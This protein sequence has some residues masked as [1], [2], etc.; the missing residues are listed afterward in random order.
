[1]NFFARVW[2]NARDRRNVDRRWQIVH[3]GVEHGLH[4]LVLEGRPANHRKDF[5]LQGRAPQCGL[6]FGLTDG[7]AFDV[8]MH[9]LV[10]IVVFDNGLDQDLMVGSG[11]LLQL[12]RNFF[13]FVLGAQALVVP[14]DRLHGH[15]VDDA[16]EFIFLADGQL[17]RYRA[18]V[19][20][21]ADGIDGV[22][23]VGTHLVHLVDEANAGNTVLIGLTPD[24]FR[25]RLDA[26]HGIEHGTG[27]I[28]YAQRALYLGGE[29]HVAGGIDNVDANIFPDAGGRG[30][31][32]GDAA[33]LLL[34]HPIHRRGAF[35]DLTNAVRAS[36]IEQDALRGGGL[37]G[38]DVG[39]DADI[40]ATI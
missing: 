40:P 24:G 33:L 14:D 26:M 21:L 19:E 28:E 9:Q 12:F 1:M 11:F 6:Q 30:R 23:E 22:L 5:H 17:N 18:G 8:L 39:H 3:H 2:V 10:L 13:N 27:A 7:F 15:Q 36:R 37:T 29:V 20:A 32:D 34:R 25:L 16:F 31:G 38:I 4:A 35:M